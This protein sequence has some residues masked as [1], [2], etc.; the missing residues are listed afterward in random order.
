MCGVFG[1]Y[2]FGPGNSIS[3]AVAIRARDTMTHRGPDG[4]G[5]WRSPDGRVVLA[6]RR[7][8]IID[9]SAAAAQP[10]PN[11][12]ASIWVTFNGEIYN[13]VTLRQELLA[14][15]HRFRTDHSD[16]EVLV[17][18]YEQW[19]AVG[20]AQHLAG[21]YGYGLWDETRRTLTLARDRIGVKPLYFSFGAGWVAFAS[22]I[23]ALLELPGITRDVEPLAIYHYLSFLTTPAPMTMFKGIYKLPAGFVVQIDGGGEVTAQRFWDATPG[24]GIPPGDLQGLDSEARER[25]YVAGI[26]SRLRAAVEKR[27]ISDV[28][29]G[30]FLS[31][32]VDSST[33][34][35]LMAQFMDRP[36]DTYTVGFR[37]H[38]HLNELEY[39]QL[40]ADRFGTNHHVVLIDEHDMQGYLEKLIH[41]QDEPI[42]DWVCIPLYFVSKL[43]RESGTTVIQVGEGADEQFCGYA[44]YMGYLDLHRRYWQP[45]RRWL[46]QPVQRGIA[47]AFAAA[48]RARPGIAI[49]ADIVDRAARDREHFWS[50]ATVFWDTMKARVI[51]KERLPH[52]TAPAALVKCGLFPE[53]YMQPDSFN[54][55]SSFLEHFDR[56]HPG[57]D[58]LTRMI[59]NEFK[60][61]L[62]ELLLMR[63]DKIGMSATIEARVPFLDHELVEFT[64]DIPMVDK[65]RGNIPKRL[66]K[67]AVRGL[68]PDQIIDRK[69][70]GFGAPMS[71]WLRGDF[72][73]RV[74]NAILSSRLLERGW[75]DREHIRQLCGEHRSGR[76]DNSLY[77]WTLYNL[78]AWY[79][80]WIDGQN[81]AAA[82]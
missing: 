4:A 18:G 80:Y 53:S 7:L 14:A 51:H 68:I 37:D 6:H 34:V 5:L 26:R 39:A 2:Q 38:T 55:V 25:Y 36:V 66:L 43:A 73:R 44:S 54:V 70:M 32:G 21:D 72:G 77:V 52:E 45:F 33:N 29:F 28:P 82:A 71:Q 78:T 9:L 13:H 16:T 79:D 10:M 65:V 20:L 8:S 35:A 75:F 3:D 58:V 40:V 24:A 31:G 1:F 50:G 63:V 61:R 12:D 49:Y 22:E 59:Y 27:M 30:V 46:P 74:E 15:G 67:A 57:Q 60:L 19:G 41:S 56:E 23:K 69:K 62:P 76:R 64:M 11:E 48:A 47:A 17:H 81:R 42:A